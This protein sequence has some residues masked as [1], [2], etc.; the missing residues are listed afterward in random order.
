LNRIRIRL[1][2][3]ALA[4]VCACAGPALKPSPGAPPRCTTEWYRSVERQVSTGDG[5]GHGPDIGSHEWKSVVEFKLGVRGT[6]A[7]SEADDEAWCRRIDELLASESNVRSRSGSEERSTTG[8]S[9][10]CGAEAAGS[11]E[12]MVCENGELSALDRALADV[13]AAARAKARNEHPP[14]LTA[15]QRGWIK[16]RNDCWKT[17]DRLECVT[18]AYTRR[19]AELQARYRLV[20][21]SDP[22]RFVC[23]G[24]PAN[25]VIV[26]FFHTEPPTAVAERG[27]SVS[28]MYLRPSAG[29]TRYVGRNES[30]WEHQGEAT[31]VWGYGAAE[32]RCRRAP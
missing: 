2:P 4:T 25:E 5:A 12:A 32:L 31:V 28:L 18:E 9:F 8:P 26:T 14:T 27:D 17:S 1:L 20:S 7:F 21:G 16:G 30:F 22:V 23:N 24:N 6:R 13:Y 10:A 11:I 3:A 29:G 15:E 19:I